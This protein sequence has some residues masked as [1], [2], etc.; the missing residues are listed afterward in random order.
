MNIIVML[1]LIPLLMVAGMNL[2]VSF[3]PNFRQDMIWQ[4][5]KKVVT[6]VSKPGACQS[7]EVQNA[8][9]EMV[10]LAKTK[11]ELHVAQS[12]IEYCDD[13]EKVSR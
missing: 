4:D 11:E 9:K 2:L 10:A 13:K 6:E 7:Y 1:I 12:W 5:Y 3:A 8:M